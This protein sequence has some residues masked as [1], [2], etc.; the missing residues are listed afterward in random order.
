MD[1]AVGTGVSECLGY[2]L[3]GWGFGVRQRRLCRVLMG[4]VET[5]FALRFCEE[6]KRRKCGGGRGSRFGGLMGR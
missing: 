6:G 1:G 2:G 5:P 4:G 3:K